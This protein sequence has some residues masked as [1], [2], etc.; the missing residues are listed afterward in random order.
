[1]E[2]VGGK[3]VITIVGVVGDVRHSG[4]EGDVRPQF[5]SSYLQ[6][7]TPAMSLLI[8]SRGEP[9]KLAGAV[10]TQI[11]RL[12]PHMKMPAFATLEAQLGGILAP[13]RMNM[14]LS[15]FLGVLSLSLAVLGIY[16]ILAFSVAERRREI[17]IR[18]ALGAQTRDVLRWI[19]KEGIVLTGGGLCL[20]IL[21]S[22]WISK[23]LAS[24]LWEFN[25]VN[26]KIMM[27]SSVVLLMVGLLA[28]YIPARRAARVDPVVAL[29]ND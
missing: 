5:F 23:C 6:T 16:G 11:L 27:L 9:M 21:A 26:W 13:K 17:G 25:D 18:M 28:S 20:G 12:D 29:R 10:R 8:R 24:W 7:D 2:M 14:W 3:D 19:L 22:I 15:S 4:P 1:M